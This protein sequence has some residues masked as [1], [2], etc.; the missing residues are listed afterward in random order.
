MRYGRGNQIR[1]FVE[2]MSEIVSEFGT[3]RFSYE[4]NILG[5]YF[6]Q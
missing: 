3:K 1:Q 4:Y 2:I 6:I 5:L